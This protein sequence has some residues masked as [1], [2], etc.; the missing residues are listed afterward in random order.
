MVVTG[1]E[2]LADL[3]RMLRA[4]GW[5]RDVKRK[6][7]VPN[8]G[9][10][11]RYF[12]VNFGYNLRPTELQGAFGI[13]QMPRLEPF[14]RARRENAEY[15]NQAFAKYADRLSLS[16][17]R[18]DGGSR[19][20]WFGYPLTVRPGAG[21]TREDLTRF[22]EGKGIE[23]RPIM[24][25]NFREQ[26]AIRLFPHRIAGALPN[27]ETIMRASFFLGNHQAVGPSERENVR[28][29]VDEFMAG[30]R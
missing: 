18:E 15:W 29:C 12:F 30:R 25:G 17:G 24:A 2:R 23:T 10:D 26:P 6:L 28:E 21:F 3:A 16:P 5:Q 13:H 22:L 27:A 8:P 9:I 4:H 19:S 14:I 20:V 7:D 11:E 1:D